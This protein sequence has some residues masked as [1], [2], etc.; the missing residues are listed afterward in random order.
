M[1]SQCRTDYL[2]CMKF[3]LGYCAFKE[4]LV[5]CAQERTVIHSSRTGGLARWWMQT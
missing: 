1:V 5:E 3:D 4:N 2:W